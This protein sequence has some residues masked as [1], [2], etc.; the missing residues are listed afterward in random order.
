MAQADVGQKFDKGEVEKILTLSRNLNDLE[1]SQ[2]IDALRKL[3]LKRNFKFGPENE[4][5]IHG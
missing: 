5:T 1:L 2:V 4:D 3:Q